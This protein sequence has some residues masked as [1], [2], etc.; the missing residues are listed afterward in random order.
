MQ[1]LLEDYTAELRDKR[2]NEHRLEHWIEGDATLRARVESML[3]PIRNRI[4][5]LNTANADAAQRL[6]TYQEEIRRRSD[7]DSDV[8]Q[9]RPASL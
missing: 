8:I 2:D 4:R 5:A 3:E 1:L 9:T 7:N 6:K